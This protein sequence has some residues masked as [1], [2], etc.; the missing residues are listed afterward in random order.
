M[1]GGLV[2]LADLGIITRW[3]D[4]A[5]QH[6]LAPQRCLRNPQSRQFVIDAL[7]AHVLRGPDCRAACELADAAE[8]TRISEQ[9]AHFPL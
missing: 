6:Q 2:Y 3:L 7:Q 4:C 5:N 1:D 8:L 9:G